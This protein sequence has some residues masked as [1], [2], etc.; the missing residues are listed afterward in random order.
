MSAG[1]QTTL[2]LV[3]GLQLET[4]SFT[5]SAGAGS[6]AITGQSATLSAPSSGADI[7][8]SWPLILGNLLATAGSSAF[9]LS[10]GAGSV[11]IIG[12]SA[13]LTPS[14]DPAD[15]GTTW[16]LALGLNLTSSG[17][18][19][20]AE[21]GNVELR[22]A[23]SESAEVETAGNASLGGGTAYFYR[24]GDKKPGSDYV[25][26]AK[27]IEAAIDRMMP[28][29]ADKAAAEYDRVI[30]KAKAQPI[31][32][33]VA[34]PAPKPEAT[35]ARVDVSPAAAAWVDGWAREYKVSLPPEAYRQLL[36]LGASAIAS[37]PRSNV[38]PYIDSDAIENYV[39]IKQWQRMKAEEELLLML[40]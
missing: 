38:E 20:T 25:D 23:G 22:F 39:S 17:F 29:E 6:V 9:S 40:D 4:G 30:A 12:K 11:P 15:T 33:P 10:A 31:P 28:T 8:T 1:L 7:G 27:P 35:P 16:P 5:L 37:V 3:L 24:K 14:Y 2:P 13:N 32:A 34:K 18:T 36:Q 19:L 26:K 21:A